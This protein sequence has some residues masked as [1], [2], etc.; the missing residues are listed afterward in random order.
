MV[1]RYKIELEGE[2]DIDW[3]GWLGD[4]NLEHSADGHTI[5][6]GELCDQAAL[7]GLLAR[8]RDLGVPLLLVA[9]LPAVAGDHDPASR[10][11]P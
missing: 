11:Q 9:R 4:L 8:I 7:H 10:P 1:E 3:S 2:L 6:C 5:L